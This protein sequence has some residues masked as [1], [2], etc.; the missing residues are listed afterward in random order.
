VRW[1]GVGRVIGRA[2]EV[3]DQDVCRRVTR[4]LP[5]QCIC[6]QQEERRP[7]GVT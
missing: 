1:F 2:A 3:P 5:L 4:G 6:D 7:C